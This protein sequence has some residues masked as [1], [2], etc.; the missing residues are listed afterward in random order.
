MVNITLEL[1]DD[2]AK[3]AKALGLLTSDKI[4]ALLRAEIEQETT[5]KAMS[6]AD[7][8]TWL[9]ATPPPEDWGDMEANEDAGEHVHHLR[10]QNLVNLDE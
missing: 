9:Q 5:P 10:R 6:R 1:P 7:F 4:A 8:V 2:I 3:D